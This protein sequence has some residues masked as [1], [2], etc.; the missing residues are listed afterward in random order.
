MPVP[1]VAPVVVVFPAAAVAPVVVVFVAAPVAAAAPPPCEMRTQFPKP[2]AVVKLTRQLAPS[3]PPVH[4]VPAGRDPVT[5]TVPVDVGDLTPFVVIV[6]APPVNVLPVPVGSTLV[7]VMSVE[8]S[9]PLEIETASVGLAKKKVS[10]VNL[11]IEVG[12]T[13]GERAVSCSLDGL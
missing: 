6:A 10:I 12:D 2:P 4:V 11:R 13:D 5:W 8:P 3:A 7:E 1:V 9:V